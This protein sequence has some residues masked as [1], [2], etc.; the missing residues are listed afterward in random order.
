MEPPVKITS[1]MLDSF[2][3]V[4]EEPENQ[5]QIEQLLDGWV[6]ELINV[7][8]S[9][10]EQEKAKDLFRLT[11]NETLPFGERLQR[12]YELQVLFST[13]EQTKFIQFT[14]EPASNDFKVKL[15]T[16]E[17]NNEFT[18][19]TFDGRNDDLFKVKKLAQEACTEKPEKVDANY[20]RDCLERSDG[21]ILFKNNEELHSVDQNSKQTV[22]ESF[23][24]TM[25]EH[26]PS[27]IE[28][29]RIKA[30]LAQDL[31][32]FVPPKLDPKMNTLGNKDVEHRVSI[33]PNSVVI[34]VNCKYNVIGL[35]EQKQRLQECRQHG[36]YTQFNLTF[37]ILVLDEDSFCTR[38]TWDGNQNALQ[39][40]RS[41]F[42]K[43]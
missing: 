11:A 23:L 3:V 18:L 1:S 12:L 31:L 2:V 29:N 25:Q 40:R 26:L 20:Q 34:T 6:G 5:A 37:E 41:W 16:A 9:S 15:V 35:P 17:P 22:R 4:S 10:Q 13:D 24:A 8:V 14:S 21:L 33:F 7:H 36:C 30:L 38:C 39:K 43:N 19:L 42:R 27:N 28:L 32:L